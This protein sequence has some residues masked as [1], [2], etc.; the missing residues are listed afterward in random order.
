[1]RYI[2]SYMISGTEADWIIEV[3]AG[4]FSCVSETLV[5]EEVFEAVTVLEEG[6]GAGET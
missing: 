3:I 1:M 5:V 6:R 4:S 2:L